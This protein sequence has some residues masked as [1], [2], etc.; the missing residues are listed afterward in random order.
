MR[1]T[2]IFPI[3]VLLLAATTTSANAATIIVTNTNDNGPGSLRQ[4]LADANNG[5]TIN[6]AVSGTIGVTSAELLID[7]SITV[8]GPGPDTLAVSRTSNTQ[9]RV[10]QVAQLGRTVNIEGLKISNGDA[11]FDYGGGILNNQATLTITNC[12]V[13]DNIASSGGGVYNSDGGSLTIVNSTV[14]GND[15]GGGQNPSGGGVAGGSLTIINSTISGNSAV[16]AFPFTFGNGGGI[17]GVGT[18]TNS[19]IADNYAGLDGGGISGEWTIAS[20]TVSNNG[21]GGGTNNFPGTGGGVW[22]GGTISNSTISGNSVFG[23]SF[24]GPGL[25]GGI[26]AVGTVTISDSTFS[27]NYIISFGNGGG[28]YNR[29]TLEIGNTILNRTGLGEN[30][31]NNGGTIVSAGYNL[32][33]DD[34]GGY[35]T[36]PGD[37]INTDPLLGALQDNGGPTQTYALLPGSPAID[38]GD[39][40]FTPP[41]YYDQRDQDFWRVR[42]GRIDVGSFEVQVGSTPSPTPTPTASPTPTATATASATPT[43]TATPTLTPRPTPVPRLRPTPAPRP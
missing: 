27:D 10:F 22:G 42:N 21:A 34:G 18:I 12:S 43:A 23:S 1:R 26:Y 4:A 7:K 33:N 17:S 38:A 41:P 11:G 14:S 9:F 32:S 39:P 8:T 31:F 16:G 35:L 19:T 5:D 36:G 24:K 20:C 13:V 40:K 3:A 15:A 25:G 6:F 28:I 29:A 30:I 2:T 37:L